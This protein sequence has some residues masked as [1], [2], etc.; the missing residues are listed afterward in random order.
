MLL[1]AVKSTGGVAPKFTSP[2]FDGVP[3]RIVLLPGGHL[4]FVEGYV[5][6]GLR[7]RTGTMNGSLISRLPP[8][9]K[10]AKHRTAILH[11]ITKLRAEHPAAD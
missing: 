9:L 8:W 4:A 10:A 1:R 2:G 3:D 5:R 11:A 7:E 6:A